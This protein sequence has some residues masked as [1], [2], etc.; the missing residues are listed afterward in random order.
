M[1]AVIPC[2]AARI[3]KALYDAVSPDNPE[4]FVFMGKKSIIVASKY[5]YFFVLFSD[6]DPK[7][8]FLHS[9]YRGCCGL[10]P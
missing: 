1:T 3:C 7:E 2:L 4:K 8:I 10:R 9:S 6:P 5:C